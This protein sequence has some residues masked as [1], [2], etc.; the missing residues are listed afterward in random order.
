[1]RQERGISARELARR[2]QVSPSLISQIERGRSRPSVRTLYAIASEFGASLEEF[3]QT[4]GD[5]KES[6]GENAGTAGQNG[7][8][9]AATSL[10]A[11]IPLPAA[12]G[13]RPWGPAQRADGRKT[14]VLD[15][16]VR[17]ERLTAQ[18]DRFVDFVWVTYDVGGAS[19]PTPAL[20]R[21]AGREYGVVLSGRLT[22]EVQFDTYEL[23]PGDSISFDSTMH[24]RLS[25]PGDTPTQAIWFVV[26]R[27]DDPRDLA[28]QE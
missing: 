18:P 22:V 17:W 24:H 16:G 10:D 13:D 15:S 26:G 19:S 1:M 25:N 23:G 12:S 21:H 28:L 27:R 11:A 3:F 9:S 4:D 2:V 14:I 20:T 5:G 8:A 6:D 7:E